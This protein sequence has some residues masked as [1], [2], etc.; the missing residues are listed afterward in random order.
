M[1]LAI[2]RQLDVGGLPEAVL[3]SFKH[4]Q[5]GGNALRFGCI[6]H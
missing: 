3:L 6:V 2:K 4:H 1:Q 5:R